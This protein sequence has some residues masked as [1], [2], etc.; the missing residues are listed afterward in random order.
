MSEPVTYNEKELLQLVATGNAAAFARLVD[1]F[2]K[3][4]YG[5]TL[6][7]TKSPQ[8]AEELTQDIF[9]KVWQTRQQLPGIDNFSVYLYV[10]GRNRVISALRKKV[11]SSSSHP[12]EDLVENALSPDL[13]LE[14]KEARTLIL[15]SIEAMPPV[16]KKVFLMSRMEGLSYDEIALALGISRNT[17]KEHIVTGLGFLRRR[18]LQQTGSTIPVVILALHCFR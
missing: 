14:L 5:N 1:L 8:T 6:A 17:V 7:L 10:V 18:L 13:Q 12:E 16:R 4:V 11:H 2:W 9:L 3:K 15:E